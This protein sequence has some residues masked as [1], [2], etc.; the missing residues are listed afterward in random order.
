MGVTGEPRRGNR[1][2]GRQ[3]RRRGLARRVAG[4][5]DDLSRLEHGQFVGERLNPVGAGVFGGRE[6][7]GG[8]IEQR[9]ADRPDILA[10][11]HPGVSRRPAET[12]PARQR[13]RR[14]RHQKRRLPRVQVARIGQRPGRDDADDFALDDALGLAGVFHL[15]ANRDPESLFH[16]PRDVAVHG[17]K[18][19]AAHRNAAAVGVFRPRGQ[20]Q[21]EGP[22]RD[23]RV[24]V[25]HLVEVAH[26]KEQN[27]V[28]MLLLGVE[29]LAHRRRHGR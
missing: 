7:A 25:E 26:A 29:I 2:A 18:R 19:H 11:C 12:R 10:A 16:Q 20:R 24:F 15:I 8:E 14:N 27:R 23:E 13:R 9:H 17:V 28:A 22:G 3:D 21:L 4:R 1:R 6:L 5:H